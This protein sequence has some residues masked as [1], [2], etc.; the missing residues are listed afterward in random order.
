MS[1]TTKMMNCE[2]YK[3]ALA[4]DPGFE[5]GSGHVDSCAGCQAYRADILAF[6]EK[7]AAAM[8]IDVPELTL[9][10]LPDID[11]ANVVSLPARRNLPKPA[12]LALA[13]TVLLAVFVAV[14]TVDFGPSYGTLEEQVLAHVDHE[15]RALRV[16]STPV[17]ERRLE[18]VVPDELATMNRA[19]GL[20]TY[21]QSCIINGKNVPHLVIQGEYGPVTIL[22]MP[23]EKISEAKSLDGVNIQG[24]ILPVG[25]GSI[26]I[27][28]NREEQLERIKQNVLNSVTWST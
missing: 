16:S 17:S 8:A 13:A 24:I 26:A 11:A 28:G 23:D 18:E 20:I 5:D 3:E 10:E 27:I 4:T 12:W 22:L 6:D 25:S 15:P 2:D 7:I 1:Q 21:A 9:P 19:V 14:R